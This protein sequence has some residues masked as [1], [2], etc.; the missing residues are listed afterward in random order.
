MTLSLKEVYKKWLNNYNFFSLIIEL[1]ILINI[2]FTIIPIISNILFVDYDNYT[3]KRS[4][5]ITAVY[6]SKKF[7]TEMLRT[8]LISVR[9]QVLAQTDNF[10]S[11]LYCSNSNEAANI[12]AQLES[13]ISGSIGVLLINKN[14]NEWYSNRNWFLDYPYNQQSAK[15]ALIKLSEEDDVVLITSSEISHYICPYGY[16][17][18]AYSSP[19]DEV[20]EIYFIRGANYN[21]FINSIKFNLYISI[22]FLLVFLIILIKHIL[23]IRKLGLYSYLKNY[24]KLLL[25]RAIKGLKIFF[26]NSGEIFKNAFLNKTMIIIVVFWIVYFPL[27]FVFNSYRYYYPSSILGSN[28]VILI[29]IAALL[30][31]I[32]ISYLENINNKNKLTKY[33][34]K[35]IENDLDVDININS[36][37]TFEKLGNEVNN[38]KTSYKENIEAGLKNERLK[39]ELITNVSHDLKTPLTSIINYVDILKDE[40]LTKEEL[41]DY[42]TILDSKSIKLKKLVEDLFE[43]SKMSSGQIELN[44]SNLDM[45]E[46]I[47]QSLG[48]LSFLGESRNLSFKVTGLDECMVLVDGARMSRVM[49]N[50]ICNAIKYSLENSRIY[51]DITALNNSIEITIKNISKYE[52]DFNENEILERF[53]RGDKSRN[54]SIEGSGLGLAIATSIVDLHKGTLAVKCDGDLFKVIITLPN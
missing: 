5:P 38:L 22:P 19:S 51:I 9:E 1:I 24:E 43:M 42:I 18:G 41:K 2:S 31:N 47:H 25:I 48:E 13:N 37:G 3:D 45:V 35:V 26:I 20:E 28:T 30:L 17:N 52:I 7:K 27:N 14:T 39:T 6:N 8:E 29:T 53:V 54:S 4:L 12:Q 46:L 34:E 23:L 33:I 50:L 36:L 16:Y 11:I 15:E 44:K 40:N 32:I 49:D 21:H 10:S